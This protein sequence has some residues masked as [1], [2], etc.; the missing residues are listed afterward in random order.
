[1]PSKKKISKGVG[2]ALNLISKAGKGEKDNSSEVETKKQAA[3]SSTRTSCR[4][5]Q[6]TQAVLELSSSVPQQYETTVKVAPA[7]SNEIIDVDAE[8]TDFLCVLLPLLTKT[9]RI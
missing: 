6:Q 4:Q 8:P 2:G 7:P 1:M 3:V 9:S 5:L